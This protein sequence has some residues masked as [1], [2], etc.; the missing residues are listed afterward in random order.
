MFFI[1]E[2]CSCGARPVAREEVETHRLF[3]Q[4]F[5]LEMPSRTRAAAD[6]CAL[7]KHMLPRSFDSI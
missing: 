5:C 4:P 6:A 3:H 1:R 2:T 7:P